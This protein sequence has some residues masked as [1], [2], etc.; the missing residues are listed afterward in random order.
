MSRDELVELGKAGWRQS[1]RWHRSD[2][3]AF[4]E[5]E[6]AALQAVKIGQEPTASNVLNTIRAGSFLYLPM[7]QTIM[8]WAARWADQGFPV[9]QMGHKYAAALMAT[10][11]TVDEEDI[12]PPWHALYILVPSK[13]LYVRDP[14]TGKNHEVTAVSAQ[15]M[16]NDEGE[17]RWSYVIHSGP[18]SLWR[19][20]VLV[21][22]MLE[23]DVTSGVDWS[24]YSF[25][26]DVDPEDERT[27]SL[28]QRLILNICL[29][30]SHPDNV[31]PLGKS[32]KLAPSEIRRHPEPLVRTY[33]VGKPIKL[34]CRSAI[35]DFVT[36]KRRSGPVVQV[37]VRGH[38]KS[39]PHGPKRAYRKRIWIEPYWR[40][41]EDAP[42]LTRPHELEP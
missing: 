26:V 38:W 4:A 3:A 1:Y 39:Q 31:K 30:M 29:A 32:S 35:H 9:V 25:N 37:L 8:F 41:P 13:L 2:D 34:D 33:Q 36:G 21:H 20:G 42:I 15:H 12:R 10:A 5:L 40:G 6:K 17:K 7:E 27:Y 19:H 11:V 16:V 28:V 14:S 23:A 24:T 18:I 22:E